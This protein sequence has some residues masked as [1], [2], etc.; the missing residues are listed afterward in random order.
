MG[1]IKIKG[2]ERSNIKPKKGSQKGKG[3]KQVLTLKKNE[4]PCRNHKK[5]PKKGVKGGGLVR[6]DTLT[7]LMRGKAAKAEGINTPPG[8][9]LKGNAVGKNGC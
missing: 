6:G 3:K 5:R 8:K 4:S 9:D 2:E 7:H 1:S